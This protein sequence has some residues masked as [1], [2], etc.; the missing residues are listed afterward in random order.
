VHAE[1][2]RMLDLSSFSKSPTTG[3]GSTV[4]IARL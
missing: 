3:R 4:V 1:N 2:R